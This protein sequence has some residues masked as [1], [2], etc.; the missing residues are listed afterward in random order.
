MHALQRFLLIVFLMSAAA[1]VLALQ[2]FVS[3][4][5][6]AYLAEAVGGDRVRVEALVGQGQNPH[7][8]EPGPRQMARL[9]DAGIFVRAGLPYEAGWL[10][11]IGSAASDL[12]ILDARK[13]VDM[14]PAPARTHSAGHGHGH[15]H[16]DEIDEHIWTSPAN[17]RRI[18][19]QMRDLFSTVDPAGG[20]LY[21]ANF[22]AL[23]LDLQRLDLELRQ[24]L[25]GLAG[26]SFLVFHPAWGY[27]ARDYGLRQVAIEHEGKEPGPQSLARIADLARSEGVRVILVQPQL[28]TRMAE[29]LAAAIGARVETADPLA[30]DYPRSLRQLARTL[31]E[32]LQ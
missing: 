25:Q 24:T 3:V 8:F 13:G 12:I 20:D 28:G 15:G 30:Q 17:A 26:K 27:F 2:V 32:A 11:R 4:L 14:L 21:A 18:A 23:D 1:P 7:G 31:Q 10:A 16:D 5:P 6:L 29:A 19:A 9:A 22:D